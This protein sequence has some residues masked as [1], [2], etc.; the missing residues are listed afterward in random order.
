MPKGRNK[1][2]QFDGLDDDFRDLVEPQVHNC[3]QGAKFYASKEPP[4]AKRADR[5]LDSA[6]KTLSNYRQRVEGEMGDR[7]RGVNG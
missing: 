7:P 4:D 6:Q 2:G 1:D 3:I 5:T